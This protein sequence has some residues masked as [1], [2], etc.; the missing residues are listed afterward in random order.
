MIEL[1]GG[2]RRAVREREGEG[3]LGWLG[4][5]WL[6]WAPGAA[7]LGWSTTLSLFFCFL[8]FLFLISVLVFEKAI[9]V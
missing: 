5:A 7:Q 3:E 1:T 4:L 8:F 6:D 2:S 9:Q